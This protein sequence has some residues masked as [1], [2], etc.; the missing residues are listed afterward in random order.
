MIE[1]AEVRGLDFGEIHLMDSSW[2][3]GVCRERKVSMNRV[4]PSREDFVD[5]REKKSPTGA[6]FIY[7]SESV[8]D[9]LEVITAWHRVPDLYG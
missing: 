6:V 5:G 8:E 3:Y 2:I 7:E 9:A 4:T 1:L